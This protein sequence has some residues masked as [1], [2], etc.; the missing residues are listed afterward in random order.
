MTDDAPRPPR[1]PL[2][3]TRWEWDAMV[4]VLDVLHYGALAAVDDKQ[5]VHVRSSAGHLIAVITPETAPGIVAAWDA[6][7][8]A[9]QA[10]TD[11]FFPE[12][13]RIR[14]DGLGG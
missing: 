5:D 8:S 11:E 2:H 6:A 10:V 13:A 4:R 12:L 14:K 1:P 9:E 3:L 7:R